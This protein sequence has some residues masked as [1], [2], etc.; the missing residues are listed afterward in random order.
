MTIL[1]H[2]AINLAELAVIRLWLNEGEG[3]KIQR[4]LVNQP[5]YIERLGYIGCS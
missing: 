4:L 3:E 2:A 1:Y 5:L